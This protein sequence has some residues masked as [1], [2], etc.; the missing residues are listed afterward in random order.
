MKS[1]IEERQSEREQSPEQTA[2]PPKSAKSDLPQEH[3]KSA[4][5]LKVSFISVVEQLIIS[6]D[7]DGEAKTEAE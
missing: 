4:Q 1:V 7:G 6:T 2:D 3:P 5:A